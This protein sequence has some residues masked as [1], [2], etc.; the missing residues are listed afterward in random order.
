MRGL[1]WRA[2]GRP[3]SGTRQGMQS[4]TE[5]AAAAPAPLEIT[6]EVIHQEQVCRPPSAFPWQTP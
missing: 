2:S 3:C 4:A 1:A 6:H 5:M